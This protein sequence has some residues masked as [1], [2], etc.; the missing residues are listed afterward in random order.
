MVEKRCGRRASCCRATAASGSRI[1]WMAPSRIADR[2]HHR[3]TEHTEMSLCSLCLCG[4][5]DARAALARRQL[6]VRESVGWHLRLSPIGFTTEAQS[7]QR[8]LCALCASLV[9][10]TRELLSRDGSFG[11]ANPLDGTF[12]YRR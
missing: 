3:G 10:T 9:W 12:A 2:I 6:R 5:D 1:R 4:V 7:T 8:C 11:F